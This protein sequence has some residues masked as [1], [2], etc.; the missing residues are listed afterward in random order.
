MAEMKECYKMIRQAI[1]MFPSDGPVI[2]KG[3]EGAKIL[4]TKPPHNEAYGRV[5][6]PKGELGFWLVSDNGTN[7]YRLK[8]RGHSFSNLH[9]LNEMVKET[10]I[11]D[12]VVS[13][14]SLD[15]VLGDIDR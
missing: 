1:K 2:A 6:A 15:I 4:R 14:G 11:A 5:E 9:V 12:T 3:F 8:A 7:P 10:T 13:L